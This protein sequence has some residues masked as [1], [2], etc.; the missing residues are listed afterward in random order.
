MKR[1]RTSSNISSAAAGG[2]HSRR[3]NSSGQR[4]L[5]SRKRETANCLP[6]PASRCPTDA[7][8]TSL[9]G[10]WELRQQLWAVCAAI[11]RST[12]GLGYFC[13]SC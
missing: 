10:I 5:V 9:L 11:T 7:L 2:R 6:L 13:I 8:L 3:L 12:S 4:S 1:T